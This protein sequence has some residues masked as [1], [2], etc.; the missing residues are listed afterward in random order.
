MMVL[1]LNL[2]EAYKYRDKLKK[3]YG[4]LHSSS[5]PPKPRSC[6]LHRRDSQLFKLH[7]VE[8]LASRRSRPLKLSSLFFIVFSSTLSST[9]SFK[10]FGETSYLL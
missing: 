6:S 9:L 5:P 7:L 2:I 10:T 3:P 4:P 8:A 1:P